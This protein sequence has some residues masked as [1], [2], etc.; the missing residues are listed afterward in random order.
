MRCALVGMWEPFDCSYFRWYLNPAFVIELILKYIRNLAM[1]LKLKLFLLLLLLRWHIMWARRSFIIINIVEVVS[2]IVVLR[3]FALWPHI[4]Q[5]EYNYSASVVSHTQKLP[6][7]FIECQG[8]Y[9]VLII[10]VRRFKI[11]QTLDQIKCFCRRNHLSYISIC[12]LSFNMV[13][14]IVQCT[15]AIIWRQLKAHHSG[16]LLLYI[17]ANW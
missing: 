2:I 10:S 12:I 17:F 14:P 6:L 5:F 15:L 4:D 13:R 3:L 1:K 8:R 7:A 9:H 16:I 11:S